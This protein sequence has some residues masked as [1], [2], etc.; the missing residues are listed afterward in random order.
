MSN[1]HLSLGVAKD[2]G[3]RD[4]QRVVQVAQGVELPLL[5]LYGDEELLDPLQSQLITGETRHQLG[6]HARVGKA[7]LFNKMQ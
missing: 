3:L 1:T 4:G 5:S 7:N 2:D 6:K